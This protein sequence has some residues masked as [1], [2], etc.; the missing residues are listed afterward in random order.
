MKL[1]LKNSRGSVLS[2][3]NNPYFVLTNING[4][5]AASANI[6]SLTL[7]NLDG[8]IV[9]NSR[10]QPRPLILDLRIRDNV[11]VEE[12]KRAVLSV[13]KIKQVCFLV[14]EQKDRKTQLSGV[15]EGFEMPRWNNTVTMQISIHC[16]Q[17]FW[18]D[19]NDVIEE[20]SEAIGLHYFTAEPD[21]MLYFPAEGIPFGEYDFI[22][23]KGIYNSGDVAVGL[24]IDIEAHD[25]VT[26][27]IIYDSAGRF[28]GIGYGNGSKKIVMQQGDIIKINTNIGQ[29]SVTMN[30]LSLLNK[31]KPS[32][33]WLQL[34]AG[35]NTFTINSSDENIKNMTFALKYKRR[36]V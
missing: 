36:F 31:L 8:D 34:E 11:T 1:E 10:V 23:T 15:V 3:I 20:I 33:S 5:T 28:F 17:P 13:V 7:G 14:W 6:S 35:E 19:I 21:D 30:G 32:S 12:A 18:E 27:P 26:N 9:N 22:R 24:M 29:K 4:Q 25:T 2:L 16:S